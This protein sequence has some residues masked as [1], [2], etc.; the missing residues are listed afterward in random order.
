MWTNWITTHL[1]ESLSHWIS[2]LHIW[3]LVN[4]HSDKRKSQ[5]SLYFGKQLQKTWMTDREISMYPDSSCVFYSVSL[6]SCTIIKLCAKTSEAAILK[7]NSLPSLSYLLLL[8]HKMNLWPCNFLPGSLASTHYP[9]A[10]LRRS[11]LLIKPHR[12]TF[13]TFFPLVAA[14]L[15]FLKN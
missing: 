15:Q 4:Y 11:D 10:K 2:M 9:P 8:F 6:F 13:I 1:P 14:V 7:K 5:K 12:F 3:Q